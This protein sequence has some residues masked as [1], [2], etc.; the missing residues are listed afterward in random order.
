MALRAQ[1]VEQATKTLPLELEHTERGPPSTLKFL[2][3]LTEPTLLVSSAL[4][5]PIGVLS[6][7]FKKKVL[8][9]HNASTHLLTLLNYLIRDAAKVLL[10]FQLRK[11]K[12]KKYHVLALKVL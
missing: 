1:P 11:Q 3:T 12:T 8:S 5:V 2:T 9:F 4:R 7:I 6:I 10:F